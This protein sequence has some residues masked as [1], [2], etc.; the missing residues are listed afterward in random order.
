MSISDLIIVMKDGKVHQIGKPQTVY[1][2]PVNLFVAQFLGTPAINTLEG[3]IKGG[4]LF[5]GGDDV[6]EMADKRDGKVWVGIRPEGFVLD[7]N[8]PFR[9]KLDRV[10]VM[11]R[12]VSVVCT[13]PAMTGRNLRAIIPAE[14]AVDTGK[15][16]VCFRLKEAKTHVFDRESEV[17]L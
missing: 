14:N 11:G 13:H 12:D 17:R 15:E 4:H 1:D 6:M 3:E 5:I 9:C 8:G 10:E 2:D 16:N 7:E